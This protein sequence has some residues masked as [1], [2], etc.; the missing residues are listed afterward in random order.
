MINF[1]LFYVKAFVAYVFTLPSMRAR[2][3]PV[4]RGIRCMRNYP[5]LVRYD[6][7]EGIIKA[8]NIYFHM[9]T[10]H[11]RLSEMVYLRETRAMN[12]F[13]GYWYPVP[14]SMA[15]CVLTALSKAKTNGAQESRF[16]EFSSRYWYE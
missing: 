1:L 15:F 11:N 5:F 3:N 10:P 7:R 14:T 13:N 16:I 9:P 8:G 6:K 12:F 2:S 4:E